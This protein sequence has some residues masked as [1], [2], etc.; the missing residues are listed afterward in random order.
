[1]KQLITLSLSTILV[2][3]SWSTH[4]TPSGLSNTPEQCQD[5]AYTICKKHI[6]HPK[7]YQFCLEEIYNTCIRQ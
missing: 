5:R 2:L 3:I 6:A 1:M 4:A 7:K